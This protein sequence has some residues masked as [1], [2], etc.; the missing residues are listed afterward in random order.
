[1]MQSNLMIGGLDW[2]SGDWQVL[3]TYIEL[4]YF[5]KDPIIK[6]LGSGVGLTIK[7]PIIKV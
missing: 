1:M 4:E 5:L 7:D 3:I 2:S 6:V